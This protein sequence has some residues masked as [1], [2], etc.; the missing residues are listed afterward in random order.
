MINSESLDFIALSSISCKSART[1]ADSGERE[2]V[3]VGVSPLKWSLV[4][5]VDQEEEEGVSQPRS[6]K[7][8]PD[9]AVVEKVLEM[10]DWI[11]RRRV[12]WRISEAAEARLVAEMRRWRVCIV[13]AATPEKW[14]KG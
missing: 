7:G 8:G 13:T 1:L 6:S 4:R 5:P 14:K 3:V 9:P 10:V 12:S 2:E 11:W